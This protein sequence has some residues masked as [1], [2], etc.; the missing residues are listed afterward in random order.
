VLIMGG[1]AR[2]PLLLVGGLAVIASVFLLWL[3]ELRALDIRFL[4][5]FQGY[6][7]EGTEP[8]WR[9]L[10][11]ALVAGALGII[12]SAFIGSRALSVLATLVTGALWGLWVLQAFNSFADFTWATLQPGAWVA[13]AGIALSFAACLI[14]DAKRSRY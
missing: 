14:G 12:I 3:G 10:G 6:G 7:G 2:G 4:G 9:S 8:W 5:I 13:A 11:A 1:S